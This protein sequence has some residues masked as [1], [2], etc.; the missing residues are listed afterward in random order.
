MTAVQTL[1]AKAQ[2]RGQSEIGLTD[3]GGA[4]VAASDR[5]SAHQSTGGVR[6][7][8]QPH[9]C[10]WHTV[11]DAGVQHC[12]GGNDRLA[13]I[14]SWHRGGRS[15]EQLVADGV[16]ATGT[17]TGTAA[18]S[19]TG[20]TSTTETAPG[21]AATTGPARH[22]LWSVDRDVRE[23]PA[24]CRMAPKCRQ[25]TTRT[26]A[27]RARRVSLERLRQH[28]SRPSLQPEHR[29]L[30]RHP[31]NL[32]RL[33][34]LRKLGRLKER[35]HCVHPASNDRAGI[36]GIGTDFFGRQGRCRVRRIREQA[37]AGQTANGNKYAA[38]KRQCLQEHRERLAANSGNS[39]IHL[40]LLGKQFRCGKGIG[41]A[42]KE[43]RVIGLWRRRRR[44]LAIQGGQCSWFGKPR[45]RWRLGRPQ[46][47][48]T[49][50]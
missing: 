42:G 3:Y 48:R 36:C 39:E 13:C 32:Q 33:R 2:G 8:V 30:C 24:H 5:D 47:K 31:S 11:C 6:P 22:G 18:P 10:L 23:A 25:A 38:C 45:W 44:R 9:G 26:P 41:R 15:D 1:R 37:A 34:K 28:S 43:Q 4:A 7:A 21:T 46:M 50:L 29:S 16:T 27:L 40:K 19:S 49:L 35:Q 17:A 14:W 20:A 12:S